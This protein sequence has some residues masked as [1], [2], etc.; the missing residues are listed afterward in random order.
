MT[1]RLRTR[2]PWLLLV[3]SLGILLWGVLP[4]GMRNI[5]MDFPMKSDPPI[6]GELGETRTLLI[7]YP[8][9]I[10][11]GDSGRILVTV[12][13]PPFGARM[14][15]GNLYE[16]YTLLVEASLE[17]PGV[18]LRPPGTL[19]S[20]LL[21]GA[22]VEFGWEIAPETGLTVEG[23][24]W[25]FLTLIAKDTN[26]RQTYPILARQ[27]EVTAVTFLGMPAPAVRMLGGLGA[28]ASLAL[29]YRRR[30]RRRK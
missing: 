11:A 24:V 22:V 21:P 25:L 1:K 19:S 4:I 10:R 7:Q 12:E 6:P 17:L 2:L 18:P 20:G 14:T 29:V 26:Q 8:E 23:R 9:S 3:L 27:I 30:L 5:R 15:P 16:T 13:A 28:L